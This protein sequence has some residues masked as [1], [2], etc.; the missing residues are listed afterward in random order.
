VRGCNYILYSN[1]FVASG[2]LRH[3]IY[4]VTH[5]PDG[6]N[7]H[8][9]LLINDLNPYVAARNFLILYVLSSFPDLTRGVD[10][11]LHLW[12]SAFLPVAY[13]VQLTALI[14][15]FVM[16]QHSGAWEATFGGYRLLCEFEPSTIS[17]LFSFLRS[18]ESDEMPLAD[19]E[20]HR[21]M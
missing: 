7:G 12:Y 3:V 18:A 20:Y 21:V 4:S 1:R 2:D 16:K 6:F 11:A 14:M 19:M 17:L 13:K 10:I 5:L 8:V 9:T 15:D